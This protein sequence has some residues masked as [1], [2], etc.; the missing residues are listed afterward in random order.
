VNIAL[1]F[2]AVGSGSWLVYVLSTLAILLVAVNMAPLAH[3]GAGA[4]SLSGFVGRGLGGTWKVITAW[5]LILT[6]VSTAVAVLVACAGYL[7]SLLM[8]MDWKLPQPVLIVGTGLLASV[9]ALR[10]VRLSTGAMLGLEGLSILL[11]LLLCVSVLI[12]LGLQVDLSQLHMEGLSMKGFNAA[13]LIGILSFAGFETSSALGEEAKDPLKT[14]PR[15]L[16]TTPLITGTFFVATSYVLVLGFN[17]YQIPVAITE[18]PLELLAERL[19]RPGLG[20][21]ISLGA[22]LSLFGGTVAC[23]VAASRALF[24]LARLGALPSGLA[25]IHQKSCIPKNAVLLCVVLVFVVGLPVAWSAKPMD[26]YDWFG[27][28]A[29]FGFVS[30]YLL[31]CLSSPVVLYRSGRLSVLRGLVA[32]AALIVLGFVLVSSVVPVPDPPMN[33]LPWVFAGLLAA[34]SVFSFAR[35][36]RRHIKTGHP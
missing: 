24:S 6:Y 4:G 20:I 34:G 33:V 28:F 16:I 1:V 9:L 19:H 31:T 11:V 18:D 29:T 3:S 14:I 10:N 32:I 5:I 12:H 13:L 36:K 7:D 35:L 27:T 15:A 2:V 25:K 26:V 21:L 22:M 23:L 17:H 8:L 30:A